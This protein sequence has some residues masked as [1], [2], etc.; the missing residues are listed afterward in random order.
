MYKA[1]LNIV[2]RRMIDVQIEDV[3]ITGGGLRII[4]KKNKFL[5]MGDHCNYLNKS[6]IILYDPESN[7]VELKM[8]TEKVTELQ[9]FA[10]KQSL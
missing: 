6:E 3:Q 10:F 1:N 4:E 5:L 9:T 8:H 2:L 7:N